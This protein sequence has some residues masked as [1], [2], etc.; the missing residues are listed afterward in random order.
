MVTIFADIGLRL[1]CDLR[2]RELQLRCRRHALALCSR[3]F[4]LQLGGLL[5]SRLSELQVGLRH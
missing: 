2:P 1:L 5:S 4:L 3:Q